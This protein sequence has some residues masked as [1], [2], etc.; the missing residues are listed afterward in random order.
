MKSIAIVLMVLTLGLFITGC[1]KIT[2]S[3]TNPNTPAPVNAATNTNTP[4]PTDSAV[5]ADISI[6]TTTTD[7]DIGTLDDTAVSDGLPQ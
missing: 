2:P 5:A 3:T 7:P 1:S 4:I 6:D